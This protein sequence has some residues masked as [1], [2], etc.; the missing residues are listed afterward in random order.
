MVK[1]NTQMTLGPNLKTVRAD[2][3][4]FHTEYF[5]NPNNPTCLLI[6][7]AMAPARFWT[8]TF[9]ELLVNAGF[10]VIRYD[11]RDIGESCSIDWQKTPYNLSDLARDAISILDAYGIK[12]AHFVGHSMGGYIAQTI[13]LE[14]PKQAFSICSISAGPIGATKE[15]DSPLTDQEQAIQGKTW[16]IMLGRKD[17]RSKESMIQSFLP[18]WKYLNGEFPLN[19]SMADAYTRDLILR[20][21]HLIKAG[22]NHELVMRS[23]GLEQ[24]RGVLRKIDVPALIIHGELD[25]L[26][27]PRH[28]ISVAREITGSNLII[29][30]GMGH[31]IFHRELEERLVNL[32]SVHMRNAPRNMLERNMHL[33]MTYFAGKVATIDQLSDPDVTAI[34]SDIPDDMF[35]YVLSA[36]FT[37]K[38]TAKRIEQVIQKFHEHHT[39]FSWWVS[40]SDTPPNLGKELIR[41]GLSFKERDVGMIL[42]LGQFRPKSTSSLR[43]Q[44]VETEAGLKDFGSIII[45]IGGHPSCYDRIFRQIP[46]SLLQEGTA[47]EMHVAYF[48]TQPIVT[49]V[50]VLGGNLAGIYYVATVPNQRNK[51]YGTAMMEYLLALSLQKGYNCSGLEASHEGLPLYQRLAFK[52]ICVFE[53]YAWRE[54][55]VVRVMSTHEEKEAATQ[56]RQRYFFDRVPIKDPYLWT[57]DHKDHLHFILYKES[58]IVGYAHIQLWPDHRAALRIIV[59][60]E[61]VRGQGM[62]KYLMDFCEQALKAQGITLLQTEASPAAYSFYKKLGYIEMPFNNPDG[63]PTHPNDRAMGKYL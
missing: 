27:L 63:E 21:R 10:F 8:D 26:V 17:G 56:F 48:D 22:N 2:H 36:R 37:T 7:G 23:L 25:P 34:R 32:L 52:E 58:D 3:L 31:M 50:L 57:F 60:D 43:F 6:A 24:S 29:I 54:A 62:G 16:E 4:H 15:T 35:N 11:H 45:A 14:F 13:G 33:H 1:G 30:P 5:G 42:D 38:N 59:I 49:G 19:E 44:R 18:I 46:V 47:L 61:R 53:E 51:G 41:H 40:E 55:Y 20:S 39:S 28:G 12:Q 9:C